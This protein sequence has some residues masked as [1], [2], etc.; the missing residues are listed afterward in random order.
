MPT[1]PPSGITPPA[2]GLA[3]EEPELRPEDDIPGE[4]SRDPSAAERQPRDERPGARE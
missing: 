3:R 4:E 2:P 1:Q